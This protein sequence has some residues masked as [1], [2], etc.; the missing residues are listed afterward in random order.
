[1]PSLSIPTRL[2]HAR[3]DYCNSRFLNLPVHFNLIVF[4]SRC[5][6]TPEFSHI[7]HVVKTI[8]WL[9]II[10]RIHFKIVSL[11]TKFFTLFNLFILVIPYTVQPAFN[12]RSSFCHYCASLFCSILVFS[13][14]F[15]LRFNFTEQTNYLF[16]LL[17]SII[18]HCGNRAVMNL[19]YH[20]LHACSHPEC[21]LNTLIAVSKTVLQTLRFSYHVVQ[22]V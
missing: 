22:W 8:R 6:R 20:G 17:V 7:S 11:L 10:E 4:R 14:I 1:M 18:A 5:H 9:Q 12:T 15:L 2:I 16:A 19:L 13:R 3:L 21:C